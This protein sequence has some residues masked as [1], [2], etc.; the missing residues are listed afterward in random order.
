MF[1][2]SF[3]LLGTTPSMLELR[4][5]QEALRFPGRYQE[6]RTVQASALAV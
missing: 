1:F 4:S 6:M 3:I 5:R 2:Y